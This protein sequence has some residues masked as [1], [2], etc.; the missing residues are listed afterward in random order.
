MKGFYIDLWI[1]SLDPELCRMLHETGYSIIVLEGTYPS[2]CE[3]ILVFEK[4]I[5]EAASRKEL[6]HK[7]R[8]VDRKYVVSVKPRSVESARVAARDSRVDTIILDEDSV[9]FMDKHQFNLMKQFVKPLEFSLNTWLRTSLKNRALV[10]R[11]LFTCIHRYG[12]PIVVSSGASKWNEVIHPKSAI[13]FLSSLL[14]IPPII[15]NLYVSVYPRDVLVR[16]GFNIY[17]SE[18]ALPA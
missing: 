18:G 12:L 14:N 6:L 5:V 8:N 1:K 16:K 9:R 15:S 2:V 10:H 13:E 7:L 17:G 3:G 11:A 4:K